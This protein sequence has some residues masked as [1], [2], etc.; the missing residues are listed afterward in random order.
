VHSTPSNREPETG[1][2]PGVMTLPGSR[3]IDGAPACPDR[4]A[5]TTKLFGLDFAAQSELAL[6]CKV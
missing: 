3:V 4:R 5:R 2:W 1:A 6:Q